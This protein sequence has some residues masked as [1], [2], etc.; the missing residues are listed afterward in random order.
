MKA[1]L[2]GDICPTAVNFH[3]F[4]QEDIPALFTDAVRVFEGKDF[5][6]ANLECALTERDTPIRKIGGL[7]H[8]QA[9]QQV[10]LGYL[11][12]FCDGGEVHHLVLSDHGFA[13]SAEGIGGFR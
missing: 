6:V 2:L 8:R 3:L 1:L 11:G 4:R 12:G 7:Q 5:A 13:K 10:E 9:V